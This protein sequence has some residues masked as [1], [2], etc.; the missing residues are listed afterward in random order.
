V[1]SALESYESGLKVAQRAKETE[2]EARISH[3]IGELYY[4]EGRYERSIEFQ[5]QYLNKLHEV[6]AA[7]INRE[8][9]ESI[10]KKDNSSES[11][12]KFK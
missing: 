7:E 11:S 10:E 2:S 5:E 9:E 3:K 4:I 1:S 8:T 12:L 6:I